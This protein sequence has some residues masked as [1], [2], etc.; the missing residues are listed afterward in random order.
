MS[1]PRVSIIVP[2]LNR[3]ELLI[4]TLRSITLQD[5]ENIELIVSN[6][7]SRDA[8]GE[9]LSHLKSDNL[10]TITRPFTLPLEA[11]V[12]DAARHATGKYLIVLSDDDL[13]CSNYIST[14]VTCFEAEPEV[15]VGLGRRILIDGDSRIIHQSDP[16]SAT[17]YVEQAEAWM[18]RYFASR[19]AHHHINT[20]FSTFYRRSEWLACGGQPTLSA[21]FFA[22]TV[23]FVGVNTAR[24]KVFYAPEAAF[25]YRMHQSQ[26]SRQA[27]PIGKQTF[28][29]LF[30]FFERL[31][32]VLG[33]FSSSD[34]LKSAIIDYIIMMFT[35]SCGQFVADER[36]DPLALRAVLRDYL[37]GAP[38]RAVKS[39]D[40]W[41]GG[42]PVRPSASASA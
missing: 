4:Q 14:M 7:G 40:L 22:D 37:D 41:Q 29:G 23:P 39:P 38:Q 36:I 8:T 1:K 3:V 2:T 18:T 16:L 33:D 35:G 30:Q 13:I 21:S 26:E 10:L 24:S 32:E 31:K 28:L 19:T 42:Q 20:I 5:Y 12:N 17:A 15:Q 6:N 25:L 27:G 34:A 9:F 11:N